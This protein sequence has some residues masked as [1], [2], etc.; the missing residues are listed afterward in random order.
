MACLILRLLVKFNHFCADDKY[1]IKV[2]FLIGTLVVFQGCTRASN[3]EM[4][5]IQIQLPSESSIEVSKVSGLAISSVAEPKS[6][7]DINCY[8]IFI[9]G[10]DK[11]MSKNTCAVGKKRESYANHSGGEIVFGD[12][13]AG[14]QAGQKIEIE[15]PSGTDRVVHLI[16]MRTDHCN[17]FRTNG[18]PSDKDSSSAFLLG[19]AG[20]LN[21]KPGET[22]EVPI[23][24]TLNSERTIVGC[25]GEDP[26]GGNSDDGDGSNNGPYLRF[27]GIGAY[28]YILD[29]NRATTEI[30]YPFRPA[31]YSGQGVPW[32]NPD[33]KDI[34]LNVGEV[35]FGQF[36][37]GANCTSQTTDLVIP[38]GSSKS[39]VQYYFKS[40][41]IVAGQNLSSI[42][43]S[44][45]IEEISGEH[46][47]L[48]IGQRRIV[49][50]G[51][52]RVVLSECY[53]YRLIS[54]LY[55]GGPLPLS[56]ISL[57]ITLSDMAN[58]YLRAGSD[59]ATGTS[60][61][62]AP[63][64][65]ETTVF[66]RLS[67][68]VSTSINSFLMA[69]GYT[70]EPFSI[71]SS[72]RGSHYNALVLKVK[73]DKI[74]R[75]ECNEMSIGLINDD[76]GFVQ[77]KNILD[78]KINAPQGS[79]VFYSSMNC[80][81]AP[82]NT[83]QMVPGQS[84]VRVWF[85]AH[86]IPANFLTAG[87]LPIQVDN[88]A[89]KLDGII[90]GNTS[91]TWVTVNDSRRNQVLLDLPSFSGAQI[92]GSHE[93]NGGGMNTYLAIP[94]L[95][96]Y[97]VTPLPTVQ[98]S[99][100]TG[101]GFSDCS[102]GELDTTSVPYRYKWLVTNATGATNRYVRFVYSDYATQEIEVSPSAL[103]GSNFKVVACTRVP[104]NVIDT[105]GNLAVLSNPAVMCLP[106][107][108]RYTKADAT[109]YTIDS[110]RISLIGHSSGTS[111]LDGANYTGALINSS[112][113]NI[114]TG[115]ENRY[116][117]NLK[118]EN[119]PTGMMFS[120][121]SA[122]VPAKVHIDNINYKTT[123]STSQGIYLV[124]SNDIDLDFFIRKSSITVDGSNSYGIN[125]ESTSRIFIEDT[126]ISA[127]GASSKGIRLYAS[128]SGGDNVS[129]IHSI[130][131]VN[132]GIALVIQ[133]TTTTTG[134]NN[135]IKNSRFIR[136]GTGSSSTP[137]VNIED[138]FNNSS[139]ESNIV[140]AEF[141]AQNSALLIM[142]NSSGSVNSIAVNANTFVQSI[143]T[144]P[145]IIFTGDYTITDFSENAFA[146]TGSSVNGMGAI[147]FLSGTISAVS[148]LGGSGG[149]NLSCGV[150]NAVYSFIYSP[151]SASVSGAATLLGN[152][153][154][155]GTN[156][157]IN[158][159]RCRGP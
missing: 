26:P 143:S 7:D 59:C 65:S 17:D 3:S 64:S 110:N 131:K 98:C 45:N 103:Y 123:A 89:L 133:N 21:L 134:Y 119:S 66:F 101:T 39:L 44:G 11:G 88:G 77:A 73:D 63:Y 31:I 27:D 91:V 43:I 84:N 1:M 97:N 93:F 30:C 96:D 95:A 50:D 29:V 157:A 34:H 54:S 106:A 141:G 122:T 22:Q 28:D 105:L 114:S 147:R 94:L 41:E 69:P 68:S 20:K 150:T 36:Y 37:E 83:V 79:G 156:M 104:D 9:G 8:G 129:V 144:A 112:S 33:S 47:T 132:D 81:S 155:Y 10:P 87:R 55:E 75:G 146:Y 121:M 90:S 148:A 4:A 56:S 49:V 142:A 118:M 46:Y 154:V 48:S 145:G 16:G 113:L 151:G 76:G 126:E 92:V 115:S 117:A 100:T 58:F 125:L 60:A 149:G 42:G 2:F 108:S 51:P 107:N 116:I 18:T 13:M 127:T 38:T 130:V 23:Q 53:P 135:L 67:S 6:L 102:P 99:A 128:G 158:T 85:K 52:Q 40:S 19:T 153:P 70:I 140:L 82:M 139:F 124:N 137:I 32:I 138:K 24:M 136:S 62:I 12:W 25:R 111:V 159:G 14:V 74:I 120:S 15:I 109:A 35:K 86:A 80:S 57:S 78:I 71:S 5:K 152:I 61:S 72:E